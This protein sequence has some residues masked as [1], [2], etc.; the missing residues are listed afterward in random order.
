MEFSLGGITLCLSLLLTT[1]QTKY[2]MRYIYVYNVEWKYT[3]ELMYRGTSGTTLMIKVLLVCNPPHL[4]ID[5]SHYT[6]TTTTTIVMNLMI[7]HSHN[8]NQDTPQ[9]I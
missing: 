4:R 2:R 8:G 1:L 9:H 3:S 7:L 6:T 5:I